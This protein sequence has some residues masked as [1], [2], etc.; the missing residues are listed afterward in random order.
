M[1]FLTCLSRHWA[2]VSDEDHLDKPMECYLPRNCPGLD[3]ETR[4]CFASSSN[5]TS[6]VSEQGTSILCDKGASGRLCDLCETGAIAMAVLL[7]KKAHT[8]L[9]QEHTSLAAAGASSARGVVR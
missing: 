5:L 3:E 9:A 6:C 2:D 4:Q 7:M 1:L 8:P